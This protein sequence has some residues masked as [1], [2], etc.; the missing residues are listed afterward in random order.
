MSKFAAFALVLTV[1]LA[2]IAGGIFALV[3]VYTQQDTLALNKIIVLDL[4]GLAV[5]LVS[6]V[7]GG[8]A[9]MDIAEEK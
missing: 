4:L 9:L 6:G 8:I 1:M 5:I 7:R 3:T 2:G